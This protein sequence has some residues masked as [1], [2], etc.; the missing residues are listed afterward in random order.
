MVSHSG[1]DVVVSYSGVDVVVSHSGVEVDKQR[2]LRRKLLAETLEDITVS[3]VSTTIT[4][5]NGKD[6]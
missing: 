3:T 5:N 1:V 4:T 2:P 6:L